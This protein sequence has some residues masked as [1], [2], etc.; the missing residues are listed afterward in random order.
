MAVDDG[1]KS[2]KYMY[3]ELY[4]YLFFDAEFGYLK[5]R[6]LRE[7][8]ESWRLKIPCTNLEQLQELVCKI[9]LL[10]FTDQF[11]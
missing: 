3:F 4:F 9:K 2:L 10:L 6:D 7:S 1:G 11:K 8:R 5:K